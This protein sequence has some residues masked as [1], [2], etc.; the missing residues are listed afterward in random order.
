MKTTSA[1]RLAT[2]IA[3]ALAAFLATAAHA[4]AAKTV[5]IS[6]F[7]FKPA[8]L[9]VAKGTKVTFSNTSGIAHSATDKGAFDTGRI[10]GGKTATVR[11]GQKGTFAYHCKIHPEM[12]GKVIVD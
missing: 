11:F 1:S 12:R 2:L 10:K 3:L 4:G 7:A 6:N 8:T 5:S 9:T